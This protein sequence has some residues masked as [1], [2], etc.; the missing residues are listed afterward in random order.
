MLP[1][2]CA[3]GLV[4]LGL[5]A[6]AALELLTRRPELFWILF[7]AVV[8]LVPA[9]V[10]IYFMWMGLGLMRTRDFSPLN[11]RF[12]IAPRH[13]GLVAKL[14]GSVLM[15]AGIHMLWMGGFFVLRLPVL[16]WA[17]SFGLCLIAFQVLIFAFEERK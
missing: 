15:A 3:L 14:I 10:G 1:W 8:A 13:V 7:Y 6:T 9:C 11:R 17:L 16:P 2:L 4:G 12:D 5:A